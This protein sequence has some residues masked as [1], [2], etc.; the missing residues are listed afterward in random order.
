M[1][2]ADISLII[3]DCDGTLVDTE[4]LHGRLQRQHIAS[5]G[6]DISEDYYRQ[7]FLGRR[8]S[9]TLEILAASHGLQA[10]ETAVND[11]S[12]MF[13]TELE[14]NDIT[15]AGAQETVMALA[16]KYK[17]CVASNGSHQS[18]FSKLKHVGL[19]P[20]FTEHTVFSA[21]DLNV[22]KP[23][24]DVFLHAMRQMGETDPAR[25]IVVEDSFTGL[26]AGLA[27]GMKT[28]WLRPHAV[29]E[30]P[31]EF[32]GHITEISQISDILDQLAAG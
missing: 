6:V 16:A 26:R 18:T 29:K 27:A 9:T 11:Y 24:P 28:I 1:I 32:A 4:S 19:V 7:N 21:I 15:V 3:F 8:Y 5:F 22:L 10:P 23:A 20:P 13:R 12:A 14:N 31:A 25:V 30:T 2:P 17:V